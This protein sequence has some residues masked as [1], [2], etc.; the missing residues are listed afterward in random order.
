M[1]NT[2]QEMTPE[3]KERMRLLMRTPIFLDAPCPIY[4]QAETL[5]LSEEQKKKLVEIENEARAK[6][7]AVL[8]PEQQAKLLSVP[9][10][11]VKMMDTYPPLKEMQ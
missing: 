5:S 4:A 11:P 3:M 7:R 10:K 2:K 8:T 9:D 1:S 6:A